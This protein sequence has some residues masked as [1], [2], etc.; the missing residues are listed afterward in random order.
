M[1]G[2]IRP[3]TCLKYYTLLCGWLT[4]NRS[5]CGC[6]WHVSG[7]TGNLTML[8]CH[9]DF[10]YLAIGYLGEPQHWKKRCWPACSSLPPCISY[11]YP[12]WC[13]DLAAQNHCCV[14]AT[15]GKQHKPTKGV[16]CVANICC[17]RISVWKK[18]NVLYSVTSCHQA[19]EVGILKQRQ[20]TTWKTDRGEEEGGN[21]L[22]L[23]TEDLCE[24]VSAH[25]SH[26]Y[27]REA[28]W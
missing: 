21:F 1:S 3:K 20:R 4:E 26:H 18:S 17:K 10:G 11:C 23:L 16:K 2:V 8:I 12:I 14:C 24:P 15:V 13:K 7:E 27:Q 19:A 28:K 9:N 5:P 6:T 25:F 22:P